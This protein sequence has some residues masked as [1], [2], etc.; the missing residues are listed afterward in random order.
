MQLLNVSNTG[1]GAEEVVPT[2]IPVQDPLADQAVVVGADAAAMTKVRGAEVGL[3]KADVEEAALHTEV[4]THKA[5]LQEASTQKALLQQAQLQEATTQ[6][7]LHKEAIF[8][9]VLRH[10]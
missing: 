5:Q 9:E 10:F 6:K 2:N 3:T 8:H 1:K 7:V 4:N